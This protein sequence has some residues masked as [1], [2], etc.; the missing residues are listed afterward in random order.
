MMSLSLLL[1]TNLIMIVYPNAKINLG[2]NIL[3]KREDGY[4]DI[5]SI[6][7]PV[8]NFSDIL[9]IIE[10][11]TFSFCSTGLEIPGQEN[12][13]VKAWRL[14]KDDFNIGNVNIHLH[15]Q[16]F[17]GAGLGGGSSDAAFTLKV[18]NNIFRLKLSDTELER[19]A[20]S[21]GTDCPFFIDNTPKLVN[22]K[23]EK[24]NKLDLDLSDYE[25][26]FR[27]TKIHIS[28]KQAYNIVDPTKSINNLVGNIIKLDIDEWKH[29]LKNDFEDAIFKKYPEL[30]KIK[31]QFYDE[32][33]IFSSMSG[34]G[35]VIFGIF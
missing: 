26:R 20:L 29:Y 16:I 25:I 11:R 32:G 8:Y 5:S 30:K 31:Q 21:I 33:A 14:L 10:S 9:E 13:C 2:L 19:Y 22:G 3:Q 12:S 17:I 6:L 27:D 18:L 34:S 28:T 23:G 24:M 7:Y 35:S 1:K 4:H 15:K